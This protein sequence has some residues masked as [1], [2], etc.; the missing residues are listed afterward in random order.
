MTEADARE[1]TQKMAQGFL[2]LANAYLGAGAP[3]DAVASAL[4]GAGLSAILVAA[5]PAGVQRWLADVLDQMEAAAGDP[6][7]AAALLGCAGSA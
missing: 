2:G 6:Q 1:L 7:R 5:G 3:R 4:L